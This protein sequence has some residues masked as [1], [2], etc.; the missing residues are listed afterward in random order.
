MQLLAT[1]SLIGLLVFWWLLKVCDLIGN[2][3]GNVNANVGVA[4]SI[5]CIS[6]VSM[7]PV[8]PP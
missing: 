8:P 2:S 7:V 5:G 1:H 4:D 6:K 3:K